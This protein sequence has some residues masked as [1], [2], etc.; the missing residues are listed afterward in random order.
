MD[1]VFGLP[2]AKG[3]DWVW[4]DGIMTVVDHATKQK[5]LVAV[6]E[7]ITAIDAADLF[8]LWVVR[9]FDVPQE[10]VSDRDPRFM[11]Y[12]WQQMHVWARACCTG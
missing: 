12:F 9:P 6:H 3:R 2:C 7:G 4:Y 5:T 8:L 10:I 1:F 11:S